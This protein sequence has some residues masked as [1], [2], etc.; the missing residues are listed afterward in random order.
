VLLVGPYPPPFG[1]V[2]VHIQRLAALLNA[3]GVSV[4][5]LDHF[6][7]SRHGPPVVGAL[8]RNPLR[9]ATA[10]RRFA[11]S[12]MHYH[13]GGRLTPLL[14]AALM[15]RRT[16][17]ERTII[18]VHGHDLQPFLESRL[19]FVPGVTC[20]ALDRF[21]VV[22]A[23]SDEVAD[24][25]R[26]HL[27]GAEV[28]VLPAYLPPSISAPPPETRGSP[29]VIPPL[30][31]AAYDVLP[32]ADGDLYGLDVAF[33]VFERLAGD[34]PSLR[35]LILLAHAPRRRRARRYLRD[36][37]DALT[38]QTQERISV[39]V[40]HDLTETLCQGAIFLR[41]TR[42][43]GDAVSVRE[44]LALGIP[45]VASDLVQRPHGT[46]LVT[47]HDIAK[48]SDAVAETLHQQP[49]S[50]GHPA[51]TTSI[52]STRETVAAVLELY[53]RHTSLRSEPSALDVSNG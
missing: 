36:Q 52:P 24:T 4:G 51:I 48:W 33:G 15:L 6:G 8:K 32:L 10:L 21:D 40:G 17:Y 2:S 25:L 9:Y 34:F 16:R 29:T 47:G 5:V 43:D 13:H 27:P 39:K 35:L 19:P 26:Q 3:R 38:E 49:A 22:I 53:A 50:D 37:V 41:P 30:V 1:G 11:A 14:A 46:R 45:V 28:A 18:T 23:V 42:R 7:R 44:A 12:V 20:W 31:V